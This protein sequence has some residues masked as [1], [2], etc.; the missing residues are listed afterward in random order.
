M[1]EKI[2]VFEPTDD[3]C[4]LEIV[5]DG[6]CVLIEDIFTQ[7]YIDSF[8]QIGANIRSRSYSI[9]KKDVPFIIRA[10]QEFI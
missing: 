9:S 6:D 7:E 10:L 5:D 1:V 2:V 8:N 3:E 4:G